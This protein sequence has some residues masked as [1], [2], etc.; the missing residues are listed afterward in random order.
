MTVIVPSATLIGVEGRSVLVE[1]HVSTGL[2]GF[3]VVGL[4]DAACRESRD[5]VRAAMLSSGLS[6]PLKRITVNLAPSGVRKAGSGLDLPI[7]MGLL[8][9]TGDVDPVAM[10]GCSFVGE[11]GLDGA[12][13]GVPGILAL[14][15]VLATPA[16]VVPPECLLEAS[17]L[18][19]HQVRSASSLAEL[20]SIM[21]GKS[22][23]R[24]MSAPGAGR[25][26]SR[27]ADAVVDRGSEDGRRGGG[28]ETVPDLI[29][30]KGQPVARRA[31]EVAAAGR[32]HLLL[33]GPPGSGKTMLARCLPGLLPDLSVP[34]ALETTRVHSAAGVASPA[35]GLIT[36]PPFRSPHHSASMASLV[37]GGT[38]QMRPGEISL[39]HGGVLFL[40]EMGELPAVVL[41]ALRQPLED[42]AI[43]V[44]RA[45]GTVEYPARFILVGAMNPCPCGDGSVPGQCRCTDAAR[46]RYARRLSSPLLDRFD[47]AVPVQPPDPGQLLGRSWGEPTEIVAARVASARS[48]SIERGFPSSAEVPRSSLEEVAPLAH[49]ARQLLEQRLRSGQLSAR[50]L[51]RVRRVARTIADLDAWSGDLGV[52]HVAEALALRAA[53]SMLLPE[54]V[55]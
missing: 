12:L 36:R 31:V 6:W 33:V 23:W 27:S 55:S 48:R 11:L 10:A 35:C 46:S 3:T 24:E 4:P 43:R 29:E 20:V 51:D 15:E 2:P 40:D 8:A 37:G 7:A 49:E 13:R 39:A 16:V 38:C 54:A 32:H 47:L 53:R 5:R 45:R 26:A 44:S 17:L 28:G 14:S 1:V 22:S 41:D 30:V 21:R 50:G 52:E 25:S 42:G 34:D 18:G 19:R 9:A